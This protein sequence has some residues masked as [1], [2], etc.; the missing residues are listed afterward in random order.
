MIMKEKLITL[1]TLFLLMPTASAQLRVEL[2]LD[3]ET[4]LPHETLP[5][6][7]TVRNSS[8]QVL[9]LG[10]TEDWLTFSV[11]NTDGSVV[12]QIKPVEVRKEFTIPSAHR[13][14]L[15]FDLAPCFD[16]TKFGRYHIVATVRM[17]QW[18]QNFSS[19]PK[20]F[21]ISTGVKLW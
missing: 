4:F 13:A 7:V 5:V 10:T 14:N 11:E 2:E 17:P 9:K 12:S 8:G 1:I 6:K 3:Q 16:L 15:S 19:K 18:G 20:V 21:G